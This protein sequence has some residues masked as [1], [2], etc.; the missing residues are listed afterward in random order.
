MQSFVNRIFVGLVD[1]MKKTVE[2]YEFPHSGDD[3]NVK[4]RTVF[5][6]R[7]A[8]ELEQTERAKTYLDVRSS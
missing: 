7:E 1:E 2:S 3:G 4:S 5:Y 6:A 8:D